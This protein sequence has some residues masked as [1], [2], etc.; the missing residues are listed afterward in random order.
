MPERPALGETIDHRV[1]VTPE[2]TARLFDREVHP[3]Y[4]TAWMVRHAEEAGRLLVEPYLSP[5]EDATGYSISLTHERPAAIGTPLVITATVVGAD[6]RQCMAEIT[7]TAPF[8]VV[9]RG[10]FVQRYVPRGWLAE[11]ARTEQRGP[12]DHRED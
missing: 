6:Q 2:M 10:T 12:A 8:G 11:P 7:V 1:E 9:G 4:A 3:L 5:D